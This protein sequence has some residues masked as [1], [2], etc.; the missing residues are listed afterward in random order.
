MSVL[1]NVVSL[2][3]VLPVAV[4]IWYW[5]QRYQRGRALLRFTAGS[6]I[7][8]VLTTSSVAPAVHGVPAHRPLTGY[9]QV[10]AVASCA[11][12]LASLYPRT[13]AKIH[14]SGFISNRLD[15]NVVVF[16]GPA[17]NEAARAL[18]EDLSSRYELEDFVFDDVGDTLRIVIP[19]QPAY[20]T[21]GFSPNM[22]EGFPATDYGIV[23]AAFH[24]GHEGKAFRQ[25][26]CAGFTTYGTYAAAEYLFDD[27][28][29]L[30]RRGLARVL[31]FR[32]TYRP[33]SFVAIVSARFSRDECIEIHRVFAA[34]LKAKG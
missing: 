30:S 1:I 16:G 7:D 23:I 31:G 24:A 17:K 34:P 32:L 29:K 3:G 19:G 5:L 2:I 6:S 9:G 28:V 27:L 22:S 20:E 18:L 13:P 15:R 12:A 8:M 10:R 33:M 14:L 21:T 11:K 26:L 4:A 25:V